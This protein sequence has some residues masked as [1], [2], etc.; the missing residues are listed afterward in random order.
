MLAQ[1]HLTCTDDTECVV[2]NENHIVVGGSC[3]P[4][5]N[6]HC[7]KSNGAVCMQCADGYHV[8]DDVCVASDPVC[9]HETPSECVEC[10][11]GRLLQ[12]AMNGEAS[13]V[14]AGETTNCA[15]PS[16]TGC[17]R[18]PDGKWLDGKICRNCDTRCQTCGDA[19]ARC[20]SC[21]LGNVLTTSG[22]CQSLGADIDMCRV[23]VK[24]SAQ[25][26]ICNAGTYL[27]DGTCRACAE[28]C[29]TCI[30]DAGKC[31]EC[32]TDGYFFDQTTGD[33][34]ATAA[35]THC[36]DAGALG[37]RACEDGFFLELGKCVAC[38]RRVRHVHVARGV[39]ELR[40]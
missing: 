30:G 27:T 4:N 7:A 1:L 24:N 22:E 19:A 18:C 17:S 34:N 10:G 39:P 35:L 11:D 21:S 15:V 9:V 12:T 8:E 13:C 40:R 29:A 36:T 23:F 6:V 31:L 32:S 14:A 28:K 2:C 37:C 5:N 26:A 38:P 25:C 16:A 20:T 3:V 33:C